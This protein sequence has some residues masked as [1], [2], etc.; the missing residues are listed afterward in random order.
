MGKFN[1]SFRESIE[2]AQSERA[3]KKKIFN[4]LPQPFKNFEE[5]SDR[6]DFGDKCSV[7]M[8][9]IEIIHV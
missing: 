5:R 1:F 9:L 7:P 4:L 3:Q 2:A 8:P 6:N